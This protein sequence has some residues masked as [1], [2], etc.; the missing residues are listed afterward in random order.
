M[1]LAGDIKQAFLQIV[2][3]E[4]ERDVLRFFWVEDL[5]SKKPI[6]YRVT[7]ALFGLGPSPFLL[8]G[9]LEPHL[10][11]FATQYPEQVKE[12]REGIYVDDINMGGSSIESVRDLK[13]TAVNIFKAGGFALH[14][15]HSNESD[16]DG[17]ITNDDEPTFAKES[18]GTKP[19]ET[20]LL[21]IG[22]NKAN[23]N[24]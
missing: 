5:E 8:G 13:E 16:L 21:G 11:K 10:D 15:W 2:I 24:L 3:R 12:I 17:E 7:R 9:T 18:L 19:S 4:T 14:K 6:I 22:W 1:F 23:D 20:K